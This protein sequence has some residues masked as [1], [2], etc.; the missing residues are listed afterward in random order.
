MNWYFAYK[1]NANDPRGALK[2]QTQKYT[3][4]YTIKS[5]S[6]SPAF[7]TKHGRSGVCWDCPSINNDGATALSEKVI[8]ADWQL[9]VYIEYAGYTQWAGA[10]TGGAAEVHG[11]SYRP[12]GACAFHQL[13]H[14]ARVASAQL[15]VAF[16]V[17][18]LPL[19]VHH[20]RV[21]RLCSCIDLHA[22]CCIITLAAN[23]GCAMLDHSQH[24]QGLQGASGCSMA[25]ALECCRAET[26]CRLKMMHNQKNLDTIMY[27]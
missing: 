20:W 9:A 23:E 10:R 12:G 22:Y 18:Q 19:R 24:Q 1:S 16:R 7:P 15:R 5:I 4:K 14:V 3:I 25:A 26:L 27:Q 8:W 11:V 2:I 17:Q 6:S 13:Q 21:H